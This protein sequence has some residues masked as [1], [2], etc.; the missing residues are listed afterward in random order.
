[1]RI[2]KAYIIAAFL[3]AGM[4]FSTASSASINCSICGK[5]I[6]GKYYVS[7]R[8]QVIC[9]DCMAKYTACS[10]CGLVTKS[11]ISVNGLDFCRDCYLKLDKCSI[12]GKAITGGYNQYPDLGIKVCLE[13]ERTS[14]RC[15]NCNVPV[16]KPVKVGNA[17]LCER[18]AARAFRCRSCGEALLRDYTFF[19]GNRDLKYCS[20]CVKK[21]EAC[22][23]CGAPVG[24]SG[25]KLDDGR[26]LCPD[27]SKGAL[28]E[29]YQV[30]PIKTTVI[31]YLENYFDM[32][33]KHQ[34][35]YS[36][37]GKDFLEKKSS[38]THGDLNGLFY[39]KGEE[40][41]IYVLYGLREKDLFWVISHEIAHAWQ[42][43]NTS[44]NLA[45]E[46]LEGFAQWIAYKTLRRFGYDTFAQTMTNGKSDYSRGLRKMLDMESAGGIK[47]VFD[48]IK[49][50]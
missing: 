12:C 1:M 4:N 18:C 10:S 39:R 23:D 35:K 36:L 16:R 46:D 47:A 6:S 7:A 2:L 41:N 48:Y 8:S 5:E 33:V 34:I 15:D 20:N 28:F 38:G 9:Q 42:S 40:F 19:E 25:T 26:M 44:G 11:S 37:E 50:Q 43:E 13:C 22:A 32:K 3:L 49:T 24:V 30:T 14:L 27:C 21:Y 29:P 45:F 17:S 31:S